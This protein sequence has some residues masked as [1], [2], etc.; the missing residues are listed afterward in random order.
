MLKPGAQRPGNSRRDDTDPVR[1]LRAKA[2]TPRGIGESFQ[3][4]S[5]SLTM[6]DTTDLMREKTS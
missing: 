1:S 4:V 3:G 6:A 2:E 5:W